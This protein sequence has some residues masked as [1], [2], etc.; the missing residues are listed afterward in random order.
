M[1]TTTSL[2]IAF[3][4]G[5]NMASALIAGLL[6]KGQPSSLLHV[7][8]TDAEKLAD[9][10]AQGLNTYDASNVDNTKHAIEKADVV[11]LAANRR[12]LKMYYCQSKTAGASK[13]L[14]QLPQGLLPTA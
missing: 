11:V 3:I 9:F 2:N 4:G 8:E 12:S 5:G 7:V 10:E 1:A 13:W 14:F 6:A